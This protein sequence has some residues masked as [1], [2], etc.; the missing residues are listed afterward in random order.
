M[1]SLHFAV[2]VFRIIFFVVIYS[3]IYRG[4]QNISRAALRLC[5]SARLLDYTRNLNK[6]WRFCRTKTLFTII[7]FKFLTRIILYVVIC[8]FIFRAVLII[9]RCLPLGFHGIVGVLN[10]YQV[11]PR[12]C[13]IKMWI[14][15]KP[16]LESSESLGAQNWHYWQRLKKM[17]FMCIW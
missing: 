11:A 12:S 17:H 16:C 15:Q 4:F 9:P 14:F 1:D 3:F 10:K 7:L 8:I 13:E 5:L 2:Q 6:Q